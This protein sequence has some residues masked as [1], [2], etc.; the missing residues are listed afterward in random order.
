M[1][2]EPRSI[3]LGLVDRTDRRQDLKDPACSQGPATTGRLALTAA[4]SRAERVCTMSFSPRTPLA[5]GVV[6]S[7]LW[8]AAP[9]ICVASTPGRCSW[10]AVI[11]SAPTAAVTNAST[12][13]LQ[14]DVRVLNAR[15]GWVIEAP[16]AHRP[17][18]VSQTFPAS[19]QVNVTFCLYAP[20]NAA[21]KIVRLKPSELTL[22]L[23]HRSLEINSPGVR[24][25]DQVAHPLTISPRG[26]LVG[27]TL[28]GKRKLLTLY[29]DGR[30]Q[31]LPVGKVAASDAVQI[32]SLG[33]ARK[34]SMTLTDVT[35]TTSAGRVIPSPVIPP[36]SSSAG[37]ASPSGGMAAVTSAPWPG[38][39]F[40]PTSF[41]NSPLA[42]DAPL[43]PNSQAYVHELVR[44]V[45]ADGPWMNTTSYSVP[46][47]V[48]AANQ[49]SQHVTLDTWGPDLQAAFD[50]V[51]L[52]VDAQA[53]SGSDQHMV[54]WQPSTDKMWEFWQMHQK[55]D[56]WHARWGG[57]MD[58]VSAS[59]GYF[60]HTGQ[61]NNWGAT[62][63]GLPLL[64][65]LVTEADLQRGRID[66]ALAIALVEA[67]RANWSWPAQR[68]DG[69][70]FSKGITPIPE[71]TRFR[72]D[73]T[74]DVAGLKLP[75]IDRMLAQAAQTYGIV[76]R[77]KAGAVSFYG[78]DPVNMPT[79]PWPAAFGNQYPNNV[80]AQFPW[81]DLQA[82][83]TQ[84]SCCW[85]R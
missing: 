64:G 70:Y 4:R 47:Y 54:V 28:G 65:G 61:T 2:G 17:N 80:L 1:L 79:N 51:P 73:P 22:V 84:V 21:T 76:V 29:A 35:V 49:T 78:Q 45:S 6:G 24:R 56:G 72:L 16:L 41:W 83:Q 57:E 9:G 25:I 81:N 69:G 27:M 3:H 68:T 50:A 15:G 74:V 53:A 31:R 30:T 66:H 63:T 26:T 67:A 60:T 38:N 46:V 37:S 10:P 59:P 71:G 7:F 19:P 55:S 39:P 11:R 48:V 13:H 32:G 77:D 85:S 20:R 40:S 42:S 14:G 18:Y 36:A 12:R 62:A 44:Q 34:G 52:P 23:R 8:L 58:N 43:D 82:L 5:A 75:Y 33:P